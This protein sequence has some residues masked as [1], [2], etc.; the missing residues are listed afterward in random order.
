MKLIKSHAE[1]RMREELVRSNIALQ[2]GS[3]GRLAYALE[4]VGVNAAGAYVLNWIP[5]QSEDI[6]AVL[7]S[8][9]EVVTVE[10][11]RGEGQVLLER[12]TLA[13]YEGK[14]SRT[15]RLKIAVARDLLAST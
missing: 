11:P 5:E 13:K 7:V 10:V 3:Y 4:S 9:G 8:A 2:D 14:C 1:Q 12:E 6:Y 15:Q